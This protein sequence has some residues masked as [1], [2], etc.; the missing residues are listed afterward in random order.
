MGSHSD[1]SSGVFTAFTPAKGGTRFSHPGG[2]QA[3]DGG[4]YIHGHLS[5]K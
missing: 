1:T 3:L 5:N 2:M 4:R